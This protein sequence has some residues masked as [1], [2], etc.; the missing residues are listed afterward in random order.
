MGFDERL[1]FKSLGTLSFLD[2]VTIF[3]NGKPICD[4]DKIFKESAQNG[5]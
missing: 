2:W 1:N 4:W 3:N 5:I